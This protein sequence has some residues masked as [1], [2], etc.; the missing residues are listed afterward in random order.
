MSLGS[1]FG[2]DAS[3]F[4]GWL[5]LGSGFGGGASE[6]GGRLSLGVVSVVAQVIL[7]IG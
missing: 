2:G 6:I 7:V 3:D 4:G 1:S 5:S